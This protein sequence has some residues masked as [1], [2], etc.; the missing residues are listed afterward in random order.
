M[1]GGDLLLIPNHQLY[2][3]GYPLCHPKCYQPS[4]ICRTQ[5]HEEDFSHRQISSNVMCSLIFTV[6]DEMDSMFSFYSAKGYAHTLQQNPSIQ[7]PFNKVC[8]CDIFHFRLVFFS[9]YIFNST[10]CLLYV[11]FCLFRSKRNPGRQ[12]H[13]ISSNGHNKQVFLNF[14][15]F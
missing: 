8:H 12:S 3:A 1:D 11:N 4:Q 9:F 10:F 13:V 2:G 5:K 6:R 14:K 15:S 7:I